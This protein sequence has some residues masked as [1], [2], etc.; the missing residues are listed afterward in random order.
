M[1]TNER[2]LDTLAKNYGP[3]DI[4]PLTSTHLRL[5]SNH[6]PEILDIGILK[7]VAMNRGLIETF[8][9]LESDN[10]PVILR[11]GS[12][13]VSKKDIST[14]IGTLTNHVRTVVRI[15]QKEVPVTSV[16]R[17]LP[18]DV[19]ELIRNKNA[20]LRRTSAYPTPEYRSRM[21]MR[22]PNANSST[23]YLQKK[24]PREEDT[25]YYQER[26]FSALLEFGGP[27][28]EIQS[29]SDSPPWPCEETVSHKF[30]THK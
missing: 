9:R 17:D 8:H 15:C 12:L 29:T 22:A 16:R 6:R 14:A 13:T 3:G 2:A 19:H 18:V 7:G 23:G 25:Y 11:L 20:A 5:N 28:P 21:R 4:V 1:N 10:L 26:R 27:C 30:F 24:L